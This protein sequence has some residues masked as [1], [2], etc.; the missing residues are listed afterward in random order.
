MSQGAY[1]PRFCLYNA[2]PWESVCFPPRAPLETILKSLLY[3]LFHYQRPLLR[4]Q[5]PEGFCL[6]FFLLDFFHVLS[7]SWFLV[8]GFWLMLYAVRVL[9]LRV[10]LGFSLVL[11]IR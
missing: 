1:R 7:I 5:C 9:L 4:P 10:R 8:G 3:L 11:L 6:P 2:E